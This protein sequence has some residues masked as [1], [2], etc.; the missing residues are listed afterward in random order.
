MRHRFSI[1]TVLVLCLVHCAAAGSV[2]AQSLELKFWPPDKLYTY[3]VAEPWLH[4]VVLQNVAII[5]RS[6]KSITLERLQL[7]AL[8][9][10]QTK[11][12]RFLEFANLAANLKSFQAKY[13]AGEM[14]VWDAEYHLSSFFHD[15]KLT[16]SP[17]LDPNEGITVRDQYLALNDQADTLR[18]TAFGKADDGATVEVSA[19]L[20]LEPY[21]SKT[22]LR[23]PLVG[24]WQVA[25]GP[26]PFTSHRWIIHQEFAYDLWKL[27][28]DGNDHRGDG[29][30]YDDYYSY[31][32]PVIAPADAT[33]Y[34]LR[35][36]ADDAP[37][38][39]DAV[40]KDQAEFIRKISAYRDMLFQRG[41]YD[42][43]GGNHLILDHG[44]GEWSLL[45][46][47]K[48]G[49]I[50]VKKGDKVRQG[51]PLG[52]VGNSGLSNVPHLHYELVAAPDLPHR[53]GL[54]L[55]FS[56][57]NDEPGARV[58]RFG[59]FVRNGPPAK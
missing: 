21:Q 34:E 15:A 32:Q 51:E 33:V 38:L 11:Q 41:G 10:G 4:D 25:N 37:L 57:L 26:F 47:L 29:S 48:K 1:S 31:G 8:N 12:D 36:D 59:E 18:V 19:A 17:R 5:N 2:L 42:E 22:T 40:I 46:H 56:N 28:A 55:R 7:S 35:N 14:K 30:K 39:N 24:S 20:P 13:A 9:N 45:A 50:R 54:P 44:N 6:G 3:T 53:R 23:L 43:L 58:L 16:D 52:L 49:S 27:D